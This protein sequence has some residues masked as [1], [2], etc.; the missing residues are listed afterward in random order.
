MKVHC[1]D[2][3]TDFEITP[4]HHLKYNN[5]GCPNCHSTK[6]IKCAKCGK[7]IIV[8]RHVSLEF[9]MLC[10]EC[11]KEIENYVKEDNH[12]ISDN[13]IQ[14]QLYNR[15]IKTNLKKCPFCG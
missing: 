5:G 15:V 7:D 9:K 4:T 12:E 10:D 13:K 11:K 3:G 14:K 8:D 1:N 2:C 6:I